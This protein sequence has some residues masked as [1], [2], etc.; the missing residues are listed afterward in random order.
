[1]KFLRR[2]ASTNS[3]DP[4]SEF[5]GWWQ[6][7]GESDFTKAVSTGS[8]APLME[9]MTQRVKAIHPELVWQAREG[10]EAE[11]MLCVTAGGI[12]AAR[13]H[14]ER[15][16]RAAPP[17]GP[18]WEF[19]SVTPPPPNPVDLTMF[20]GDEE[21]GLRQLRFNV[22]VGTKLDVTVC[23]ELFTRAD[24]D[25][26]AEVAFVVLDSLLGEDSVMR[27][28]GNV[29]TAT[30]AEP[31]AV[32]PWELQS[33]VEAF[34]RRMFES[35]QA[36]QRKLADGRTS[37]LRVR[38]VEWLDRPTLELHCS[39][40]LPYDSHD[41][42]GLPSD[43]ELERLEAIEENLEDSSESD[44]ILVAIETGQNRRVLHYYENPSISTGMAPLQSYVRD[45][46]A[47]HFEQLQDPFWETLRTMRQLR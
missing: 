21:I 47:A 16:Y 23:H 37:M 42:T 19:S 20:I 36:Q 10:T 43:T 45:H 26:C 44:R 34:A 2:F 18:V 28:I 29:D 39:L 33:I 3:G 30:A 41:E 5:W 27:W 13:E 31:E 22:R 25:S 40:T 7:R 46:P 38:S 12:S 1:M 35:W 14:S 11:H 6:T 17:G 9:V 8:F 24:Q 32:E 15:W 4:I